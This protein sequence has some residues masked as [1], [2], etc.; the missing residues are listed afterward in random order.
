MLFL[1]DLEGA[2]P[3]GVDEGLFLDRCLLVT[4]GSPVPGLPAGTTFSDIGFED[5]QLNDD[6][7]VVFQ[8][9]YSGTVSGDGLFMID[10]ARCDEDVD[11]DGDVDVD[12]LVVVLLAWGSAGSTTAD[13]NGDGLVDVD[14]LAA[15]LTAWGTCP[16]NG[17]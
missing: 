9:S 17:G 13:V 11:A 16:P 14:D 15:V 7:Q 5:L 12:D 6:R 1:A 10:C 2:A 4:D 3:A 8:A